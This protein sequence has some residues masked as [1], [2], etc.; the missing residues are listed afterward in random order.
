[1]SE[2]ANNKVLDGAAPTVYKCPVCD[3]YAHQHFALYKLCNNC[4]RVMPWREDGRAFEHKPYPY[5][6]SAD[7][8]ILVSPTTA[9]TAAPAEQPDTTS[10]TVAQ[11]TGRPSV[12]DL[13]DIIVIYPSPTADTRSCDWSKVSIEQ[14]CDS[15]VQHRN[16][17]VKGF[18][19]FVR[20]MQR[21][22]ALHDHDKLS[23]IE[24]FHRDFQTGFAQTVWWDKHRKINRHHLLQE[25]GVPNDVNLVDVFDLIVDC[26]VAGMARTGEVYPLTIPHSVLQRAFENTCRLLHS[27]IQVESS[28]PSPAAVSG[29]LPAA[30]A[31]VEPEED[32]Q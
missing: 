2:N 12:E 27:H 5:A 32:K 24:G 26:T 13:D 20:M 23:D 16:D 11:S 9:A 19:F 18:E 29:N 30:A 3:E 7:N 14:L 10:S 6:C 8:E 28:K 31:P 25:D 1:M 21:Q 22:A 17:V 4:W 15:S